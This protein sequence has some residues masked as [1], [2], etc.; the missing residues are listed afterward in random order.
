MG[1][2]PPFSIMALQSSGPISL[3]D[4]QTEF[5]GS[6][7]IAIDEYYG[8]ATGVPAS[9]AIS[10]DDFYGTSAVIPPGEDVFT[11]PGTFSWTAPAGIT[12]VCVVAVG[13]G[14]GGGSSS[15]R[16]GGSGGGLA[17]R[18]NITVVPGNSYT[19]V[20]GAG[21]GAN[22]A[23]GDTYFD[24]TSTV[25]GH[26]GPGGGTSTTQ[27]GG[28]FTQGGGADG[29]GGVGGGTT[30]R[31][32][33]AH[34]GGGAGG[35][36]GAGGDAVNNNTGEAGAG[37]GG[38]A[39]NDGGGSSSDRGGGGGGTGIYGEG[40]NGQPT[41]TGTSGSGG[42]G[43]S[44]ASGTGTNGGN[45]S[46]GGN[47]G[48][49]GGGGGQRS[50]GSPGSG[51]DGALRILW[52]TGRAFPST[53][54]GIDPS[55][56]TIVRTS[57]DTSVEGT[58]YSGSGTT[59]NA[60]YGNGV[61]LVNAP[62]H[63]T[64]TPSYFAFNGTN[65][66]AYGAGFTASNLD[67]SHEVWFRMTQASGEILI[68]V[69]NSQTGTPTAYDRHIYM[70]TNGRIYFGCYTGS[71]V[72]AFSGTG[73]N[74]GNWHQAVGTYS[75]SSNRIYLYIDG[76]LVSDTSCANLTDNGTR[77]LTIGG[78]RNSGWTSGSS[79][80]TR[81]YTQA[82]IGIARFYWGHTLTAAEVSNNWEAR[83]QDYGL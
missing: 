51:G 23:G 38:A 65:E 72:T 25:R 80:T 11:T 75:D 39:G 68:G 61:T 19:V 41:G 14:G 73:M 67:F 82:D 34:G 26:G 76:S 58:S 83:R 46:A 40:A 35:Y 8:V 15:S 47:G 62:T 10:F 36:T 21:G 64:G 29:G 50:S 24:T 66:H 27:A 12:S 42:G 2:L 54:V 37:G 5:G 7:P 71:V 18:N 57:L 9:G 55:T 74:D 22:T 77:Y 31:S 45:E 17:W 13:A 63:N 79:T 69:N 56:L 60:E 1:A 59:W 70:G 53:D 16:C 30:G 33:H 48:F 20:V 32:L 78:G 81:H 52:G 43:G 49:P 4:I 44:P 28:S 3:N 6:N